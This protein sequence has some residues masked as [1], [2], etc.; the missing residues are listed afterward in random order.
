MLKKDYYKYY[1]EIIRKFFKNNDIL[2]KENFLK[3]QQII[4][5]GYKVSDIKRE[6]IHNNFLNKKS[7]KFS[8]SGS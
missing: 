4:E 5:L 3:I 7:I 1:I 8:E 6:E 2:T